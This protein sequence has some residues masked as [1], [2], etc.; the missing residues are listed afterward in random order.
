MLDNYKENDVIIIREK[1][2]VKIKTAI[3]ILFLENY[4]WNKKI[5]VNFFFFSEK[6]S[7]FYGAD[8]SLI[9]EKITTHIS[10]FAVVFLPDLLMSLEMEQKKVA[11]A[12]ISDKAL[13]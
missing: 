9:W 11:P 12:S 13:F 4:A 10:S 3:C 5:I 7:C 2:L 8:S 1:N 6:T